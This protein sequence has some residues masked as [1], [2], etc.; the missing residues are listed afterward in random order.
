MTDSKPR[1]SLQIVVGV[2]GSPESVVALRWAKRLAG[3]LGAT[4]KA[5]SAWRS[6]VVFAPY[7][8][9]EWDSETVVRELHAQAL[10]DAFGN[11]P[12][13]GLVSECLRGQSAQ[14][15][16]DEAKNAQ[17]LIVGSRGHGG[18]KGML[19]GSVS[20]ACAAHAKCPV[21]VVHAANESV[22]DQVPTG[23]GT[24]QQDAGNASGYI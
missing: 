5:V 24:Q 22:P 19:L 4:I 18:F 8:I 16:I 10:L 17:M 12:P 7:S 11:N 20:S 1:E 6:E 21:L 9:P 14:V 23:M 2:D 3:P 15:L 13:A